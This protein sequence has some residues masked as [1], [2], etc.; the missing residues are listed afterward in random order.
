MEYN[1]R[2]TLVSDSDKQ[3]SVQHLLLSAQLA[4]SLLVRWFMCGKSDVAVNQREG[5][6]LKL[7]AFQNT[8]TI[9]IGVS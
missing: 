2:G 9:K 7:S 4:Y 6:T 8:M 1:G 3:G 5:A